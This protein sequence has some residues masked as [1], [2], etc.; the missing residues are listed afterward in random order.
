MRRSEIL[1]SWKID[2]PR[3]LYDR[4]GFSLSPQRG[5]GRVRDENVEKV[6]S[7]TDFDTAHAVRISEAGQRHSSPRTKRVNLWPAEI[8]PKGP[9]DNSPTLQRWE[10][11]RLDRVP[12][13]TADGVK[14]SR[15]FGTQ[16]SARLIPTLKRWAIVKHPSGMVLSI[17]SESGQGWL[18]IR[19]ELAQKL[20]A[21]KRL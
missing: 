11:C 13:G 21:V 1:I 16:T 14:L 20:A 8:C 4:T 18:A 6:T 2:E 5:E 15:P 12:K 17:P 10:R 19:A 9:N 7:S 3:S